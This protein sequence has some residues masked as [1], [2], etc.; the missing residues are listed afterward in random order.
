MSPE[1]IASV[2]SLAAGALLANL[3]STVLLIIET[4]NWRR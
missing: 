4:A 1:A 2:V 3:A